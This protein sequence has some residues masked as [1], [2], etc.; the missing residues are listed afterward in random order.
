MDKEDLQKRMEMTD[1]RNGKAEDRKATS[2][3]YV[4]R[5][6]GGNERDRVQIMVGRR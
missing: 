5:L 1:C 4:G 6:F 3:R 2:C